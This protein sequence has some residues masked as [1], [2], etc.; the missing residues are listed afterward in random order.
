MAESLVDESV[1]PPLS[2]SVSQ[3]IEE[4]HV[5]HQQRFLETQKYLAKTAQLNQLA[6][7]Y[8]QDTLKLTELSPH[9]HLLRYG[10]RGTGEPSGWVLVHI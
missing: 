8:K 10:C 6:D 4:R 3:M 7:A 9:R 1:D 2:V 5:E